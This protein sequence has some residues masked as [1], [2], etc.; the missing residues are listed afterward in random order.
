MKLRL[1]YLLILVLTFSACEKEDPNPM[2]EAYFEVANEY[3]VIEKD[4][5]FGE[6]ALAAV[7]YDWDFGDGQTSNQQRPK[8]IQ[9]NEPGF[10]TITLTTQSAGGATSTY[11][12]E[13]RIGQYH[14]NELLIEEN[15]GLSFENWGEE[16]LVEVSRF[17]FSNDTL[18]EEVIFTTEP[19]S[20]NPDELPFKMQLPSIPLG[21]NGFHIYDNPRVRILDAHSGEELLRYGLY[22]SSGVR[23][24]FSEQEFRG[25]WI[26]IRYKP[27]F[28][29]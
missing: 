4:I 3:L 15:E 28:P 25:G 2:I 20:F 21:G 1:L 16:I 23:W 8:N 18:V 26:T 6:V 29:V 5:E 11:Q 12:E 22:Y 9:F 24:N 19:M 14:A 17:E 13:V 27:E 10:Y 7:R